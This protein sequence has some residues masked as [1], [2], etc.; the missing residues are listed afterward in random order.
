MLLPVTDEQFLAE[1]WQQKPLL[2]PNALPHF[3][4]PLS[5]EELAGLAME[6]DVES[7]LVWQE[8]GA[9]QQQRGP[10]HSGAL[11]TRGALDASGA[12]GRLLGSSRLGTQK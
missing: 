4:S 8:T 12:R 9:W 11:S 2:C 7:R 1:Y 10:I 6:A 5:A 3:R